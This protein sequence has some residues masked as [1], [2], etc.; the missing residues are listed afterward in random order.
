[1]PVAIEAADAA[2]ERSLHHN[3]A[4]ETERQGLVVRMT[5]RLVVMVVGDEVL[6]HLATVHLGRARRTVDQHAG[7]GDP[8]IWLRQ[9]RQLLSH[10]LVDDFE[11][12]KF[13]GPDS[14]RRHRRC[15]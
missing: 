1:M 15:R 9:F 10:D 7:R 5:H 12:R 4:D 13:L 11:G 14:R 6:A 8:Q 2:V 3:V